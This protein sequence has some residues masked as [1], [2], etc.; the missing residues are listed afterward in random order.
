MKK[1]FGTIILVLTVL[2]LSACDLVTTPDVVEF[3]ISFEPNGG[4]AI[5]DLVVKEGNSF[6]EPSVPIKE[7]YVFSGWFS[8]TLLIN[9]Y[10]FTQVVTGDIKLNAKWEEDEFTVSFDTNGGD[11]IDSIIVIYGEIIDDVSPIKEGNSFLGWFYDEDLNF[12]YELPNTM[13]AD[14]FTLYAYWM[15]NQFKVI[16]YDAGGSV[17][18]ETLYY[19]GDDLTALVAPVAF[20]VD[21]YSFFEW[22]IEIPD[23][24]PAG[25]VELTPLYVINQYTISFPELYDEILT[26]IVL[27]FGALITLPILLLEGNTFDGW[28][29]DA[30]LSI[31]FLELTM[32]ANDVVIYP[33]FTEGEEAL[34]NVLSVLPTEDIT[35]T[36]WHVFGSAKAALLQKYID[37][38]EELYPNITVNAVSQGGYDDLRNKTIL[39]IS[40]G[41]G[42]TMVVGYTDHI[43]TYLNGNA[44]IPLDDFIND[45]TWGIDI[46]DFIDSYVAESKQSTDRYMY[47]LPYSK[48]SEIMIFNKTLFEAK[49]ITVPTDRPLTFDELELYA[50]IMVGNGPS[51]CE[52]LI[53]YDSASNLFI[54][55]NYQWNGAYTNAEGEVLV[56]NSNTISMLEYLS[57]QFSSNMIALPLAW[58]ASYGSINFLAQDVCMTV[59]STAGISYNVPHDGAFEIGIAPIPQYD[60]DNLSVIQQGP[61]I[62]IMSNT[63]DAERLAAWLLMTYIT[64]AKNTVDWAM[65]TGYLPVRYSGYN[66]TVYQEFLTNPD[67]D[68]V[69]ESMTANAAYIQLDYSR[70]S[71]AFSN[72]VASADVRQQ[73]GIVMEAIF[74]GSASVTEAIENMLYQLGVDGEYVYID[75]NSDGGPALILT[76]SGRID[77]DITL[78]TTILDSAITWTSSNPDVMNVNGVITR[79]LNGDGNTNVTLTATFTYDFVT[80]VREFQFIIIEE[81]PSYIYT[82][83]VDIH[84]NSQLDDII[85]FQGIVTGIFNG[86]YFLSDGTYAISIFNPG[87]IITIAVGDE[88]NVKGSYSVYNTLFQINSVTKETLISSGNTNPLTA[89]VVTVGELFALDSS[90]RLIHGML[91]EVTGTIEIRG[92]YD[93]LFIVDGDDVVM[94]YYYSLDASLDALEAEVGNEVTIKVFYYTD[95]RTNGPMVVFDGGVSDIIVN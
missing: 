4:T 16:Y 44:V 78:P 75:P 7:G 65:L 22:N 83:V 60:T 24:M 50:S 57:T 62:A 91:Y 6:L 33:M 26:P 81:E 2:L 40:A 31:E 21:G 53:N 63:T 71:P 45:E 74:I 43:A 51:Q 92:D 95:H 23:S 76:D 20:D 87:S 35:I 12:T 54:N 70:Y 68:Y 84:E 55:S 66:S 47:S 85:E 27:D 28:Y 46:S 52:Y 10:D 38:F 49:G 56:N 11:L 3:T 59:S 61:N 18:Q 1:V 15:V 88:I 82:S 13:P 69:Y 29:L 30:E 19:Y 48:S 17:L 80:Y 67:L 64:N 39:A 72:M 73:A 86:G 9:Y 89:A 8:D 5:S 41:V 90:N 25:D 36:F 77:H 34:I 93:N 42:P 32:P 94:I 37:E 58:D 14:N 79:P